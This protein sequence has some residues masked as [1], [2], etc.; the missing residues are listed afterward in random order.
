M[1]LTTHQAGARTLKGDLP[2]ASSFNS[3]S[4]AIY[5]VLMAALWTGE[6]AAKQAV[7]CLH[8]LETGSALTAWLVC[9]IVNE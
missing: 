9:C 1:L 4:Q 8:S 2:P 6:A 5:A 3:A 7:L